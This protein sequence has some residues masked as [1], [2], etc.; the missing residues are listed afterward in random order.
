MNIISKLMY[1]LE[2]GNIEEMEK[3]NKEFLSKFERIKPVTS[4]SG[5]CH[6]CTE[7]LVRCIYP[8][9]MSSAELDEMY[10]DCFV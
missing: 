7:D 3:K 9:K 8:G 10:L 1:F 2:G 5:Y 4:G 6:N